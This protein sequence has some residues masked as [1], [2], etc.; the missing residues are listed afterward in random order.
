MLEAPAKEIADPARLLGQ[1]HSLRGL[2]ANQAANAL[3]AVGK[4]YVSEGHWSL[5]RETFLTMVDRHPAH[6][7]TL[8]AYRWLIQHNTSSEAKKIFIGMSPSSHRNLH[9]I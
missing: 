7:L 6:P 1:L 3:Y 5:A 2:P 4:H 8:E 9:Q